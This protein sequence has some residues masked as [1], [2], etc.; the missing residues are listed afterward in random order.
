VDCELLQ[1]DIQVS[2]SQAH[3]DDH[4]LGSDIRDTIMNEMSQDYVNN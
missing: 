2:S 1:Q 3:D 4:R